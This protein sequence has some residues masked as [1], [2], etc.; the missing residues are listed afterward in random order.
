MKTVIQVWTH[1]CENMPQTNL[2]NYWGFGDMLR[3]TI[4]LF[5]FCKKHNYRFIVDMQ[6]H[7]ISNYFLQ[8]PHEYSDLIRQ[9]QHDIIFIHGHQLEDFIM[10][11]SNSVVY[12]FT[13]ADCDENLDTETKDFINHLLTPNESFKSYISMK[14]ATLSE[15]YNILHYRLGDWELV[16]KSQ[17]NNISNYV[18]HVIQNSD[19]MDILISDSID[20]KCEVKKHPMVNILVLDTI[21]LHIGYEITQSLRDTIFEFMLLTKATKIKSHSIYQGRSGFVYWASKVYNIPLVII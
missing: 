13:N 7:N 3:G 14:S 16:G 10:N 4:R 8:S 12:F 6:L 5:Q 9:N 11:N 2:N 15:K 19:Q 21:P 17:N 1:R 18:E 20:L